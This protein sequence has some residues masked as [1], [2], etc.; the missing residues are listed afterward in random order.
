MF[1]CVRTSLHRPPIAGIVEV[2][3]MQQRPSTFGG[4]IGLDQVDKAVRHPST[5]PDAVLLTSGRACMAA[6]LD[7]LRPARVH[8]PFYTCDSLLAPMRERGIPTEFLAIDAQLQVSGLPGAND[9][10]LV[11]LINHFGVRNAA[12]LRLAAEYKGPIALDLT[13]AYYASPPKGVWAFN[14]LR[15]FFGVPDGGQLHS[16]I[17]LSAPVQSNERVNADHLL[18]RELEPGT[19]ALEAFRTNEARMST[20]YLGANV[21]TKAVMT[22]VD[23][24]AARER[25]NANFAAAHEVFGGANQLDLDLAS[26]DGPLCY[27]LLL[28]RTVDLAPMHARGL[29]IARYWPDVLRRPE[30][31]H[32]PIESMLSARLLAFPIDQRYT[33]QHINDAAWEVRHML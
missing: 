20:A 26:I 25:R 10:E 13:H 28:D 14:S 33:D 8:V 23:E 31:A 9:S 6:I 1:Q 17:P 5:H 27:P 7:Q 32:H 4:F 11:V 22:H 16:P 12:I 24:Q 2:V 30:A 3:T 19:I 29:F 21:L 18:L 15:K